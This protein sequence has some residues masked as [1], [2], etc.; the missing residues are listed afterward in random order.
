MPGKGFPYASHHASSP[1][2]RRA[3][4]HRRARRLRRLL[5]A[6]H[7]GGRLLG[8]VHDRR[9]HRRLAPR[10]SPISAS[11]PSPRWRITPRTSRSCVSLPVIA[12]ADTGY[13]NVLN[14]VR[15][16]REYE[17]AG[18]AGLHI[19][20]Q[21]APKKCGHIAGKQVIPTRGVRRQDPRRLRVPHRSR[22]R[23]HRPHRRARGHRARRR[24]RPRQP[25]RGG[26]RRPDLRRG[27]RRREDEIR[28]VAREVKAPLLANMVRAARRPRCKVAELERLGFKIVIF[29]AV[30]M[31][32]AIP[33]IERALAFLKETGT[34]WQ[35]RPGAG[36]DGHL[37]PGRLRLVARAS[38]RS[39]P[40]REPP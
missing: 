7:R 15:T 25:L 24:D 14:V 1:D 34:D 32:A 11:P 13:G 31:A 23:H 29:P 28:R 35:R 12:D 36:P 18:V 2:A 5:R 40:A 9:R 39:S 22:L 19:E 26:G 30:C 20:D 38:R 16:V 3:R 33:A 6:P 17:R 27:A 10:A 8:G 4:P 37:P 21:V